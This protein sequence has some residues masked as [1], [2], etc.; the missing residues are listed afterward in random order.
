[1]KQKTLELN[2]E[3][4]QTCKLDGELHSNAQTD[5]FNG[6]PAKTVTEN[7]PNKPNKTLEKQRHDH[8]ID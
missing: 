2:I 4:E 5:N 1:M 7:K 6:Q 8:N 3:P